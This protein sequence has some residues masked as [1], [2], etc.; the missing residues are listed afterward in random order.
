MSN[1][2]DGESHLSNNVISSLI[3]P[4]TATF[5]QKNFKAHKI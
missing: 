2:G 1:I 4:I 5:S 3:R